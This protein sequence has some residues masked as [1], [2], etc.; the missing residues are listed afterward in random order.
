PENPTPPGPTTG[1]KSGYTSLTAS[2]LPL[3]VLSVP[4]QYSFVKLVKSGVAP[5]SLKYCS[6]SLI[7]C[8]KR[9]C[10]ISLFVCLFSKVSNGAP[11]EDA[12][13]GFSPNNIYHL[14]PADLALLYASKHLWST[15]S[16]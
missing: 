15:L 13:E 11:F 14:S 1:I 10:S 6:A 7:Y 16:S 3:K 4:V 5:L 8:L 2:Q 12:H 9:S